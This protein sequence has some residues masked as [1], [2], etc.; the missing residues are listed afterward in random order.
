MTDDD[1]ETYVGLGEIACAAIIEPPK[2]QAANTLFTRSSWLDELA[3]Q[4]AIC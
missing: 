1:T 4:A 3:R 2:H